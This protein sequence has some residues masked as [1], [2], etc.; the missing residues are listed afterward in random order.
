MNSSAISIMHAFVEHFSTFLENFNCPLNFI[1]G[2]H[3]QQ[4]TLHYFKFDGDTVTDYTC[5]QIN[6][7]KNVLKSF[8]CLG[9]YV[10][11]ILL[12]V[13]SVFTYIP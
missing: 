9:T 3:L 4:L 11:I 2:P 7:F 5:K 10:S 6:F 12:R 8:Q 13:Q 1:H